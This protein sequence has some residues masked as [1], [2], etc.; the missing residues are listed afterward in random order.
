MGK[1]AGQ[2]MQWCRAGVGVATGKPHLHI[3]GDDFVFSI[4]LS[5]GEHEQ[6]TKASRS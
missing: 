6:R 4:F 3:A 1:G 2:G 5:K